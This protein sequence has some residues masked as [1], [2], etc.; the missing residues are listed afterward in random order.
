MYV[1]GYWLNRDG[2]WTY[3]PKASWHKDETGWSY[4]DT[5]GYFVKNTTVIIDGKKYRFDTRGYLV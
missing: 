3:K 1:D 2:S 4:Y 5:A